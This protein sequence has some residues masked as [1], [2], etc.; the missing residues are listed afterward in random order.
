MIRA[1]LIVLFALPAF[2][3]SALADEQAETVEAPGVT[4]TLIYADWCGGCKVLDPTV[5]AAEAAAG[6]RAVTFV[7]LDYTAKD[8]ADFMAQAETAGVAEA[9]AAHTK[10]G[11]KIKTAQLLIID[12]GGQTSA[13]LKKS[14]SAD[15][16]LAAIDAASPAPAD[17]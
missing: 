1:V 5:K 17:A 10:D 13:V 11:K 4:A 8:K 9:I 7:T 12:A 14:A 16:I 15:D 2:A 6:D 3:V